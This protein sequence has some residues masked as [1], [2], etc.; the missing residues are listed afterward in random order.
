VAVVA[1]PTINANRAMT[2]TTP[3]EVCIRFIFLGSFV[4]LV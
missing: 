3:N 2:P 4:V 1:Q